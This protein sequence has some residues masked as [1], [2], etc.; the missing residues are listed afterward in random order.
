[1]KS[2]FDP[3]VQKIVGLL[4]QQIEATKVDSDLEINVRFG[5]SHTFLH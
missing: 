3:V 4:E 1:M 2:L 5:K